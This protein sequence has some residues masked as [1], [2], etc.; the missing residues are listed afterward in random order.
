MVNS[1]CKKRLQA[2][3][4]WRQGTGDEWLTTDSL[5]PV[6]GYL[7]PD[8]SAICMFCWQNPSVRSSKFIKFVIQL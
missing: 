3:G 4:D 1:I 8:F 2:T 6:A 7:V 5:K